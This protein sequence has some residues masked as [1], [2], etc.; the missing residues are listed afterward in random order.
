L[1][2]LEYHC[3]ECADEHDGR[4]FKAPD[5]KDL[6]RF[7]EAASKLA[8]MSDEHIPNEKIPAGDESARL[9]RWGYD[10]YRQLFNDR[11]LLG[12]SVLAS[13]IDE[14]ADGE[15]KRALFTVFSDSLRYQNMVCRYDTWALKIQD[16]F[17]VHGFP[18]GLAQCENSILGTPG[19][20]SGGFRHFVKKYARA[21]SY[22]QAPYEKTLGKPRKKIRTQGETI[23]AQMVDSVPVGKGGEP[24]RSYLNALPAED[25]D[26]SPNSLDA[27]FTD[28]PYFANVQYAELM[29]FCYVWLRR[30]LQNDIPQFNDRSTRHDG[31][32]TVN[33]TEGRDIHH[34]TEGLSRAYANFARALK[35]GAPFVFTYHHNEVEAYLP[36][37]VAILDAGLVCTEA[38]PSPAEMG[39]SLHISG[40]GSSVL[41]TVFVCRGKGYIAKADFLPP[42]QAMRRMLR[43]DLEELSNADLELGKGDAYCLLLGHLTRLAVWQLHASWDAGWDVKQKLKLVRE[44]VSRICP[45]KQLAVTA[46]EVLS[47]VI[48]GLEGDELPLFAQEEHVSNAAETIEKTHF[49]AGVS[50]NELSV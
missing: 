25:V 15:I 18:V 10:R 47:A 23:E 16:I 43:R 40:T 37:A 11:Q 29:D 26:L 48:D 19:K 34:F 21:K 49:I 38:L 27:V 50:L 33:S 13:A 7:E 3:D 45:E 30:H 12:L 1:Y 8:D 14:V 35:E 42:E 9:H 20:G 31:E 28:P 24:K 22:C 2:A 4:Y 36:I 39:A 41:D 32:L 44:A 5:R 6:Q 46:G 17:S